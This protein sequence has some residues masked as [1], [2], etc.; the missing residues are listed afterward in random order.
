ME[1][2][3]FMA[4][5]AAIVVLA[6][7]FTAFIP[8]G[9]ILVMIALP[10]PSAIIAFYCRPR[11][12]VIYVFGAIGLS[13]ACTAWNFSS[14]LFYTIPAVLTGLLYGFLAKKGAGAAFLIFSIGILNVGFSY[15]SILLIRLIYEVDMPS[16]LL[17]LIGLGE[18]ENA[19]TLMTA[20]IFAYSLVQSALS[21]LFI[22]IQSQP[23]EKEKK[24][25]DL[26]LLYPVFGLVFLLILLPLSF[27]EERICYT[28]LIASLYWLVFAMG[29]SFPF[30][31]KWIYVPLGLLFLIGVFLFY[32]FFQKLPIEKA[33]L[34]LGCPLAGLLF[35]IGLN[36]FV[37]FKQK[38]APTINEQGKD[39]C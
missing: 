19:K 32:F 36:N 14:A 9:A 15:L 4:L 16:F 10:L 17:G 26:F 24:G 22:R 34:L 5:M 6:S 33:V 30:S 11:Y 12:Y 8:L 18:S 1:N 27:F 28:L 35:G 23:L 31:R 7:V 13:I 39:A 29:N 3:T 21:D 2:I 25:K 37:L 20:G 38:R